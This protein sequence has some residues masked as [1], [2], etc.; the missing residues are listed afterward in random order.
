MF[1][2]A[3]IT[4]EHKVGFKKHTPWL[5]S[6]HVIGMNAFV[7]RYTVQIHELKLLYLPTVK[8]KIEVNSA[9]LAGR[10]DLQNQG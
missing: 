5:C 2:V 6:F 4:I 10:D 3:K 8:A 7:Q 1:T 9:Q